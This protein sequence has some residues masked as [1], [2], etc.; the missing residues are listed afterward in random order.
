MARTLKNIDW[1]D[2]HAVVVSFLHW[3]GSNS[4]FLSPRQVWEV[5]CLGNGFG[6]MDPEVLASINSGFDWSHVRDSDD[7]GWKRMA[8]RIRALALARVAV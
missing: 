7:D 5:F 6:D 1:T 3:D 4:G 2:D 8:D